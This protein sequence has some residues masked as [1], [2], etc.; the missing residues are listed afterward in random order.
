MVS[1]A[2]TYGPPNELQP[3]NP[4]TEPSGRN[5]TVRTGSAGT[6]TTPCVPLLSSVTV[7][8][9]TR[10]DAPPVAA[11][12]PGAVSVTTASPWASS[13]SSVSPLML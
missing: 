3:P 10:N 13:S 2:A 9:P 6:V 8:D 5:S 7:H 1:S 11:G 4:C 12:G